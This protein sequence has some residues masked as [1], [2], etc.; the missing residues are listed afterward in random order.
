MQSNCQILDDTALCDQIHTLGDT[1][2]WMSRYEESILFDDE[3]VHLKYNEYFGSTCDEENSAVEWL[4][5]PSP[6][7]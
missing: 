7:V 2:C 4:Q 6:N 3:I 5:G 1:S